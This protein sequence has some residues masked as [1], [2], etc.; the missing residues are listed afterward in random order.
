LDENNWASEPHAG[1]IMD[2]SFIVIVT[3]LSGSG[4]STALKA[5]EDE[6]FFCMD[7]IPVDLIMK[8]IEV[9]DSA[10]FDIPK[11]GIGI[12]VRAGAESFT[13]KAPWMVSLLRNMAADVHLI[14]LEA[15][16]ENLLNRFKETRRRHPLSEIYPNLMDAIE[17]EMKIIAPVRDMADY[18]INT[19]EMNVHELQAKMK[20]IITA[21]D[22][23]RDMY[24]EIRSFGFKKG[25]PV[26]ADIVMDVRFLPNPYFVEALKDKTGSDEQVKE[27]LSQYESYQEFIGRFKDLIRS[28]LPLYKKEGR[29]YLNIAFG[30]T[31]GRHR[32]VAVAEEVMKLI[33][34]AGYN[35]KLV[36]RDIG[37]GGR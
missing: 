37:S 10:S 16:K 30:C 27:Y 25:I 29:S 18:I 26:D 7:N 22:K 11:V 5:I 35:G 4:K 31:G 14:F 13:K 36:H 1:D 3:G 2:R 15:S 8:F 17:A 28:I 12:D 32:S 20:S 23:S 24:I 19:S 21:K 6:G 34:E 9:Y 33:E